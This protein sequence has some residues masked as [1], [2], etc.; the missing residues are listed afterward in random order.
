MSLSALRG[1]SF[2]L[3]CTRFPGRNSPCL[4]RAYGALTS[5]TRAR[6]PT[7]ALTLTTRLNLARLLNDGHLPTG[8]IPFMLS[9]GLFFA[10]VSALKAARTQ[11]LIHP[12]SP[13]SFARAISVS[14]PLAYLPSGIA[15]AVGFLNAPSFS[16]ARLIGGY[17]AHRAARRSRN[18]ETP[19]SVIVLASGFVL[20]EGVFSVVNLVAK[21]SG[22]D[23]VGCWGC[24]VGG[25]GYCAGRCTSTGTGTGTA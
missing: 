13:S 9:F 22:W 23:A 11:G 7:R 8:V 25:G 2:T 17:V 6:A 15:F 4:R 3:Q 12:S 1:T 14:I 20:G 18:G 5:C 16:I 21:A 19:L 10:L 24:G